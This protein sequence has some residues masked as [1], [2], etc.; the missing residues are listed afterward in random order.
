MDTLYDHVLSRL[1]AAFDKLAIQVPPPQR[2]PFRDGFVFRYV[3]R[4]AQQALVQ[5]LARVVTGLRAARLLLRH[6]LFQ[7]QSVLHRVL[8]DVQEDI[9]FLA[10]GIIQSEL[11]DPLHQSFLDAFY[12]EE[13]DDPE[14]AFAS[15]QKRPMIPRQKIHAYL[16]RIK[17]E[18]DPSTLKEQIRTINKLYSGFV[19][20][21]SPHIMDMYGGDPPRFHLRGMLGTPKIQEHQVEIWSYFFRGITAFGFAAKAFEDKELYQ[22]ILVLMVE[23]QQK[24]ERN[25]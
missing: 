16:A 10:Y 3:E 9:S 13:F 14:S 5:K 24:S 25:S 20:G 6:G 17:G 18:G 15:T 4:T 11:N 7:E 1:E 12:E 2:V 23:F 8:D 19:H 22:R 21:A